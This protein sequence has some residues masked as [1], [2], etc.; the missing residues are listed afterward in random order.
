MRIKTQKSG[1]S[2]CRRKF[3]QRSS[4]TD[5][6]EGLKAFLIFVPFALY[7]LGFPSFLESYSYT[8]GRSFSAGGSSTNS[9]T[10]CSNDIV[11]PLNPG[12]PPRL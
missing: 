6:S 5:H 7:S 10:F 3:V 4:V 1:F 11:C 12:V 9:E 8:I 2:T